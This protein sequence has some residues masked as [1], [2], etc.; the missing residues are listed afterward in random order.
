MTDEPDAISNKELKILTWNVGIGSQG[1]SWYW[2][3]VNNIISNNYDVIFLQEVPSSWFG[4][5][6]INYI[7]T[8]VFGSAYH[9]F[10][11]HRLA[12]GYGN[13]VT[14]VKKA[15]FFKGQSSYC[16]V[17]I[18]YKNFRYPTFA[19]L[20][21][22]NNVTLINAHIKAGKPNCRTAQINRLFNPPVSLS[23]TFPHLILKSKIIMGGDFNGW[24]DFPAYTPLAYPI[25]PPTPPPTSP[26]WF[27]YTNTYFFHDTFSNPNKITGR[28]FDY[29]SANFGTKIAGD[30]NPTKIKKIPKLPKQG[31]YHLPVEATIT[32]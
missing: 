14:L 29:V 24:H 32:I 7:W 22:F 25:P 19:L 10:R 1:K 3:I 18:K 2:N 11:A 4:M 5:H 17:F 31:H 30:V 21:H 23:S 13:L 12:N 16:P 8:N 28:Q 6:Y 20:V 9:V 26:P 27:K 15:A